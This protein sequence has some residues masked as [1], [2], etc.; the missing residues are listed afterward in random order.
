MSAG[1]SASSGASG[2]ISVAGTG[3]LPEVLDAKGNPVAAAAVAAGGDNGLK[4]GLTGDTPGKSGDNP[5]KGKDKGKGKD[6]GADEESG[7]D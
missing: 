3:D 5:G 6:G 4:L 1:Q 7:S 2:E